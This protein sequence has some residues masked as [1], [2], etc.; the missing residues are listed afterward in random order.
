MG[1]PPRDQHPAVQGPGFVFLASRSS[2]SSA[3]GWLIGSRG[4]D[5]LDDPEHGDGADGAGLDECRPA[6]NEAKD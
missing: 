2:L 3:L 4:S 5:A 6:R 1:K